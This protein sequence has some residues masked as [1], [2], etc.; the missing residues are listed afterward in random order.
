M[1]G[2]HKLETKCQSGNGNIGDLYGII[3]DKI[4][5]A[6]VYGPSLENKPLFDLA[7]NPSAIVFDVLMEIA[8]APGILTGMA[9][10]LKMF[11]TKTVY[12]IVSYIPGRG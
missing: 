9:R 2:G 12:G 7:N 3:G 6:I 8:C 11:V 4:G 10:I 5:K 1:W